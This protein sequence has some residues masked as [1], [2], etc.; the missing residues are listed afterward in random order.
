MKNEKECAIHDVSDISFIFKQIKEIIDKQERDIIDY[1]NEY[2]SEKERNLHGDNI[3]SSL[4]HSDA[5]I[6]M[7]K[8]EMLANGRNIK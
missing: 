8:M 3:W 1:I 4:L 6:A 2:M 7:I 5:L